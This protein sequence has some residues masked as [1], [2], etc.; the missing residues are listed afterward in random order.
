MKKKTT[1]AETETKQKLWEK[2]IDK[3]KVKKYPEEELEATIENLTNS[4]KQTARKLRL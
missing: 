2:I 1:K 3:S 4:F